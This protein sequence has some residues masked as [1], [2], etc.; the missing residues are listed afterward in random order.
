MGADCCCD[1]T[2]SV[3]FASSEVAKLKRLLQKK[4]LHVEQLVASQRAL[5]KTK[6]AREEE[7]ICQVTKLQQQIDQ[8]GV[9]R[10]LGD[11]GRKHA[12]QQSESMKQAIKSK[13]E[14]LSAA[15]KQ[16]ATVTEERDS[17]H[18]RV[19]A[20]KQAQKQHEGLMSDLQGK[21]NNAL[22]QVSASRMEHK[23]ELHTLQDR[24]ETLSSAT[25][26]FT[27]ELARAERRRQDSEDAARKAEEQQRAA[28]EQVRQLQRTLEDTQRACEDKDRS[29]ARLQ[30]ALDA[31]D[32]EQDSARSKLEAEARDSRKKMEQAEMQ[33]C[34]LQEFLHLV[35]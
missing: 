4:T 33:V 8:L 11:Q 3:F 27:A 12:E 9:Q 18:Q 30:Q 17:A 23:S 5:L 10:K 7:L 6:C 21:Y 32:S 25:V 35:T 31:H 1:G 34:R 28:E 29:V 16:L 20:M 14:E 24:E 22:Q 2:D 13:A 19:E 15:I 26:Q